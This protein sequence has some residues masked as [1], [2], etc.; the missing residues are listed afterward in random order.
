MRGHLFKEIIVV[1]DLDCRVLC[2]CFSGHEHIFYT[3]YKFTWWKFFGLGHFLVVI[4]D[5]IWSPVKPI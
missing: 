2:S 1:S 3:D 5:V 4:E